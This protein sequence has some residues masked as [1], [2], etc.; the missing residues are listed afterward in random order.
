MDP[1]TIIYGAISLC[2]LG[3]LMGGILVIA[4]KKF[5]V[6]HNELVKKIEDILPSI[7]CGACGL[8]GCSGYAEAVVEGDMALNLCSPGG[9]E[10]TMHIAEILG[11]QVQQAQKKV[12][13]IRC[14]GNNL[15]A[16]L[17]FKY[18]GIL[19]CSQAEV[20]FNGQKECAYS[21]L[22]VG[23]C[24]RACP[25][26][27]IKITENMMVKVNPKK[28]TGCGLCIAVCP[29]NI[30]QLVPYRERPVVYQVA[31]MSKQSAAITRQQCKVGCI[32]CKLCVK[33]CPVDAIKVEDNLAIIDFEK[34]VGCT[35]CEKVCPAKSINHIKDDKLPLPI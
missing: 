17:K 13:Y 7:N 8:P 14:N 4:S 28:C 35:K 15:N 10:T 24:F 19:E 26:D 2:F 18:N 16:K 25:F 33:E 6:E 23:S 3:L 5:A 29:R 21:C 34:C 27:A 1:N 12:A 30:I 22:G 9:E 32:A 11:A 31:C 20:V